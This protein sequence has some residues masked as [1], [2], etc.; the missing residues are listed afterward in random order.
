MKNKRK[1]LK[2]MKLSNSKLLDQF[3]PF[4]CYHNFSI[5][6][7]KDMQDK[8]NISILLKAFIKKTIV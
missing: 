5:L 8:E 1:E 4:V 3:H 7:F 2:G 6:Y